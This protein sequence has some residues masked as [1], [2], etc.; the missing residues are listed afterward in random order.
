MTQSPFDMP[1][2][3]R[4]MAD[5]NVEQ[6]QAAFRQ[7]S[8]I[9]TKAMGM[10]TAAVPANDMTAGFTVVQE[11]AVRFAKQNADAGL[12]LA[13]SIG[14]AKDVQEILA[15]QT[16]YAQSQM[17]AYSFQTQEMGR[18]IAAA[19]QGMKPKA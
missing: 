8:D 2:A 18:L 17:Q 1:Q 19:M 5:K 16:K 10:W 14:K 6:A 7:F 9:M 13:S 11:A 15:L 12:A 3:M 4:D